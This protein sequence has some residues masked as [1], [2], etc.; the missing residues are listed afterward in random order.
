MS[1]QLQAIAKGRNVEELIAATKSMLA[2]LEGHEGVNVPSASFEIKADKNVPEDKVELFQGNT[3]VGSVTNVATQPQTPIAPGT[4]LDS[5][6]LPWD[7]RIHSSNKEKIASGAW[8]ARRGVN[9][10][11]VA[12]IKQEIRQRMQGG[13]TQQTAIPN[14]T[15]TQPVVNNPVQSNMGT[16]VN[17]NVGV[18][19][20]TPAHQPQVSMP[21]TTPA[22]PMQNNVFTLEAFKGNFPVIL[23]NLVMEGKIQQQYLQ[24]LTNYFQLQHIWEAND[25]QKAA[26]YSHFINEKIIQGM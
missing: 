6:G 4:E 15:P 24:D 13:V 12:K 25:E 2:D 19:P 3:A 20:T 8:R 22:L 23:G 5:E 9:K 21:A 11:E 16:A 1:S 17:N 10:D 7:S 26:V 14:N 18:A